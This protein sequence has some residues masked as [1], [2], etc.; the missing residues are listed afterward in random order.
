MTPHSVFQLNVMTFSF[1][2]APPAFQHFVNNLLYR[3]PK[4][5]NNLVGYLNNT[6]TH[7]K[8]K[9]DFLGVELSADRFEMECI[10]VDTIRDWKPPHNVKGVREFIGFCNFYC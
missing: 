10:K 4:L 9:V 7:N 1:M 6:N 8:T 3:H 5:V 2:N